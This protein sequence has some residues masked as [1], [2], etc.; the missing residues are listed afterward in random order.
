MHH[1]HFYMT[2]KQY[3]LG[4][5][6]ENL[7]VIYKNQ[8]LLGITLEVE[9]CIQTSL[10]LNYNGFRWLEFPLYILSLLI[11][12]SLFIKLPIS[13]N[14]YFTCFLLLCNLQLVKDLSQLLQDLGFYF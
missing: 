3:N 10:N 9:R 13:V 8:Q 4:K 1:R 14:N 2:I 5:I 7:Y 11:S 6:T 12:S